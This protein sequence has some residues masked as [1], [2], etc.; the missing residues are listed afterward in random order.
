MLGL[1]HQAHPSRVPM[2]ITPIPIQKTAAPGAL[3]LVV[4]D[5][6]MIRE[7]LCDVLESE[8]FVTQ[9]R[10][11][12]DLAL[13]YL[14]QQSG[15][16]GL[17]LTDINMPGSINGV[18]LAKKSI[19]LW[20]SIPVVVMSG[21]ESLENTGMEEKASFMRKPFTIDEMLDRVRAAL[22]V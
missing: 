7:L 10:E 18:D 21:F 4:E 16:V 13:E 12:A 20:P 3:I 5:E 19:Q 15:N 14:N 22:A 2:M 8:G 6:Q 11:N 9:A 17:L 1:N